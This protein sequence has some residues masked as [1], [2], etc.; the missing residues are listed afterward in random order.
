M[1][2]GCP[3]VGHVCT[4]A[5]PLQAAYT[6][7]TSPKNKINS[8]V[9]HVGST[10]MVDQNPSKTQKVIENSKQVIKPIKTP[11]NIPKKP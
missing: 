3:K 2:V 7:V 8:Q 10:G 4:C 1:Y 9:D 11:K 5:D 6:S